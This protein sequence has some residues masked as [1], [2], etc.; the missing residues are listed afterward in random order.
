MDSD[1]V[2]DNTPLQLEK[3]QFNNIKVN[4]PISVEPV[5]KNIPLSSVWI[6]ILGL[7]GVGK[8]SFVQCLSPSKPLSIAK[9]QLES[10]THTVVAYRLINVTHNGV[11]ISL[12][13]TPGLSDVKISE[14][15]I[16]KMIQQWMNDKMAGSRTRGTEIF[17]ALT[18]EIAAPATTLVTTMWDQ[19]ANEGMAS[20]VHK[21]FEQLQ[22][23]QYWKDFINRGAGIV[24]FYNTTSSALH[25]LDG[26]LSRGARVWFD[27]ER[28][29]ERN[30]HLRDTLLGRNLHRNIRVRIAMLQQKFRVIEDDLKNIAKGS[31]SRKGG[32]GMRMEGSENANDND[33]EADAD[34]V[35]RGLLL[36]D[37]EAT[38]GDLREVR[39]DLNEFGDVEYEDDEPDV[40]L[41]VHADVDSGGEEDAGVKPEVDAH[42][43]DSRDGDCEV[44]VVD[45]EPGGEVSAGIEIL[46]GDLRGTIVGQPDYVARGGCV[47]LGFEGGDDVHREVFYDVKGHPTLATTPRIGR[48]S[49]RARILRRGKRLICLL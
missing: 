23:E 25:V 40:Q 5:G 12:I 44:T 9:N 26:A 39:E 14:A 45:P 42:R 13:D 16:V 48:G 7:T 32:K 20:R 37:K 6:L 19:I 18:G 34:E 4:G 27:F 8:S 33:S 49:W 17:K 46:P 22:E 38:E 10:V 24:K 41:D 47:R 43:E 31:S 35:L 36:K 30:Q 28:I 29:I 15:R 3:L 21:Q 11:P 1:T 2:M